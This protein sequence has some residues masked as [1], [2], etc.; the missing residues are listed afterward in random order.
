MKRCPTC[1]ATFSDATAHC[2]NDGAKLAP[3]SVTMGWDAVDA[4]EEPVPAKPEVSAAALAAKATTNPASVQKAVSVTAGWD[5]PDVP[6]DVAAA[7]STPAPAP[8]P[9][10]KPAPKPVS[11]TAGW[12]VPDVPDELAASAP[13]PVLA[14]PVA[15]TPAPV[16]KPAP[17]MPKERPQTPMKSSP[18]ARKT[19][20]GMG[21]V[22]VVEATGD[23]DETDEPSAEAAAPAPA[24]S[25]PAPVASQPAP[26]P[27]PGPTA[28]YPAQ[29]PPPN[30]SSIYEAVTYEPGADEPEPAPAPTP[31]AAPVAAP[32]SIIVEMPS[33]ASVVPPQQPV[34]VAALAAAATQAAIPTASRRESTVG[35]PASGNKAFVIVLVVILLV[36]AGI[37]VAVMMS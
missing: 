10:A 18:V 5:V 22:K 7:M 17:T 16:A 1:Q 21:A 20:F 30:P 23:V 6:D 24:A 29:Y 19:L 15:A 35:A 28:V 32:P 9:V 34:D 14:A 2:P 13:A 31:A 26:A 37:G 11:V 36:G 12:D 3:V 4:P 27:A 33:P 8:A 25:Q